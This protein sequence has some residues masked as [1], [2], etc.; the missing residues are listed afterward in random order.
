MEVVMEIMVKEGVK[1]IVKEG[2]FQIPLLN[3]RFIYYA[4]FV[5]RCFLMISLSISS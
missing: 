2:V 5:T 4:F 3:Y 1:E